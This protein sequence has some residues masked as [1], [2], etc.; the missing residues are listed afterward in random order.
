MISIQNENWV[1]NMASYTIPN[2]IEEKDIA[3]TSHVKKIIDSV[4][5][6]KMLS[7]LFDLVH[8]DYIHK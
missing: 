6:K 8:C 3:G 7:V 1:V 4:K 5:R 2:V